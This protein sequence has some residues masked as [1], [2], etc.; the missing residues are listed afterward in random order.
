MLLTC[1]TRM[2]LAQLQQP[3]RFEQ[4]IKNSEDG[5]TVISLK[6]E[7]LALVRDMKK[8]AKGKS[9]WQ[10]EIIDTTLT[11]VWSTEL[12][13]DSKLSL[14]GYE[15]APQ[16]VYLLFREGESDYYSFRLLTVRFY[17]KVIE[18]SEIK[19]EV[20][21]KM[22]HF[23]MAGNNAV[24]GGYVSNEPAVLLYDQ[25]SDHPK[26]LPGLFANDIKL[27]DVRANQNQSFN[28]LLTERKGPDKKRLMLRTYDHD[29]NLL[30][31]DIIDVDPKYTILAGLTSSLERDEMIIAGTYGEGGIKQALGV[32]SVVVDPFNDQP[33]S[34]TDF[35]SLEHFLD[36]L[37]P[38]KAEKIKVRAQRQK[39]LG[40]L[41][42]YKTYIVPLRIEET[43]KGFYLLMESYYP[44][45]NLNSY[46]YNSSYY[47]PT[48]YG[49]YPYGINPYSNRYYNSPYMGNGPARNSDVR[50]I[51]SIVVK[52]D[53]SGK[54]EK[55]HSMTL[56]EMRQSGLEQVGDFAI[57]GDSILL[58]YKKEDE[59]SYGKE[60]HDQDLK[61]VF[62]QLKLTMKS[63]NDVL[64][65]ENESEGGLRFWYGNSFYVWGYETIKDAT[66]AGD[67]SRHVFYIN[68]ISA[69]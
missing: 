29:G 68:R 17:D 37:S 67:Q 5:F 30:I 32:F 47:N 8:Y 58:A 24:F 55:D 9:K 65:N 35:C 46:T 57:V 48:G 43:P 53:L 34:Y 63:S 44:S 26:V 42:D 23:T 54:P 11:K 13:L 10:L 52:L 27:L 49:Y 62:H 60:T 3:F 25:A 2:S 51:E 59:I 28:V 15:Y 19:F 56:D 61:P 6:K 45:S 21:F 38:R 69:E 50:M 64:K 20:N 12:D 41:P 33:I 16:F 22:T 66:R 31:D 7:G 36:Y 40:R 4:E 1:G 14:V 39:T 18:S